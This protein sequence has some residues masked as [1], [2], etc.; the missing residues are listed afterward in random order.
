M[1]PKKKNRQSRARRSSQKRS[2]RQLYGLLGGVVGLAVIIVVAIVL[3]NRPATTPADA[4]AAN[5]SM[6]KSKG[7]ADAPV[8]VTEYGDFQ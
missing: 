1:T 8:V 4:G 3:L 5:V 2:N 6:D 7:A